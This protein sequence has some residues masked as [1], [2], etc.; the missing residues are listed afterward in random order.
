MDPDHY[1][2]RPIGHLIMAT[3]NAHISIPVSIV[4][5]KAKLKAARELSK[6]LVK[7]A[8]QIG[9]TTPAG[10][11]LKALSSV[12]NTK[13]EIVHSRFESIDFQM[14]QKSNVDMTRLFEE[15]SQERKDPTHVLP[16]SYRVGMSGNRLLD[17]GYSLKSNPDPVP[18]EANNNN[19]VIS[20]I[21]VPDTEV[22]IS[23]DNQVADS[24]T[25]MD[26]SLKTLYGRVPESQPDNNSIVEPVEPNTNETADSIPNT[27]ETIDNNT[28]VEPVDPNDNESTEFSDPYAANGSEFTNLFKEDHPTFFRDKRSVQNDS[29]LIALGQLGYILLKRSKRFIGTI[30]MS[31]LASLGVSTIFGAYDSSQI[32]TI[33]KVVN[34]ITHEQSLIVHQVESNSKWIMLNRNKIASLETL[35][36]RLADFAHAES[37]KENG[38]LVYMVMMAEFDRIEHELEQFMAILE[39]AQDQKLHPLVLTKRGSE[40]AFAIIK[41]RA[42][43][44][45]FVPVISVPQQLT[46]M[47]T[48]FFYTN[49]GINLVVSIALASDY[50]TFLLYQF[51]P[52]PIKL[53]GRVHVK[54][55]PQNQVL[56]IGEPGDRGHSKYIELGLLDLA[57]C[58]H[59]GQVY[60]CQDQQVVHKPNGRTCLY[61][62]FIADHETAER[63]CRV[64]L[65]EATEDEVISTGH[66]SFVYYSASPSTYRYTCEN[67]SRIAGHQLQDITEIKV[68]KDCRVETTSFVLHRKSDIHYEVRP[69]QFKYTLPVLTFLAKDAKI[70]NILTAVKIMS[71]TK[72]APEI[73]QDQVRSFLEK[74][75]PNY[76]DPVPL[77]SFAIGALSLALTLIIICIAWFNKC[78]QAKIMRQATPKAQWKN[79]VKNEDNVIALK[80]LLAKRPNI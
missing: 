71:N 34:D 3:N 64:I 14:G 72:G 67:N 54:I 58:Q 13:Y 18:I 50:N 28:I 41:D 1:M 30:V 63:V 25:D 77:T 60:L 37:F 20:Q 2:F 32:S 49:S 55:A 79:I 27:N 66:D 48:Q 11:Y 69:K 39:A 56:A 40:E 9:K 44:K 52:L 75:K 53:G 19:Q 45:G 31:L 29:S 68:P 5:L 8:K 16:R 35:T 21:E 22:P 36:T 62:L 7:M 33:K 26:M 47:P 59:L 78:K 70:T 15:I 10:L 65:N 76:L 24:V 6:T 43:S 12:A 42:K 51:E 73:D 46:Q 80:E 23:P 74:D 61:S 57:R 38:A 4:P 17:G